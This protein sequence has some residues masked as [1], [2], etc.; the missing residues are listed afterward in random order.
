[1]SAIIFTGQRVDC[2][3]CSESDFVPV[4]DKDRHGDPLATDLCR[5]CG[6]VFTNPQPTEAELEQFYTDDYRSSYKGVL[7]P[8]PKHVYR[9]GLRAIERLTRL[10]PY[11]KESAHIL[12]IGAGGGEFTYLMMRAGHSIRGI[13]PNR[14]YA[15]FAKSEYA[16]DIKVGTVSNAGGR[17]ECWDVITLHHVLEHLAD[18]VSVLRS[19]AQDLTDDGI[20][21]IEV[22]N[23]EARYHGPQRRFHF[24]HLHTFSR[25]GL[26]LAAGQAGLAVVDLCLQPHTGHINVVL[27]KTSDQKVVAETTV[28][29]RIEHHLNADTPA[30]DIFT[31]RPYRRLWANLNRPLRERRALQKLGKAN[32][33]KT[34]LDQMYDPV[35]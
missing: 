3:L 26:T 16:I 20:F 15:D 22:P 35:L 14:G 12:D 34:I 4:G 5:T 6:H 13:E 31:S 25:E 24:A 7:T 8:K 21:V 33:A 30:R 1:V 23:V 27:S 32:G 17:D 11:L 10:Q 18:P 29:Q 9:A 28:A 19:L 2:P